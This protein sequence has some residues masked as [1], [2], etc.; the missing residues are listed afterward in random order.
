MT[1]FTSEDDMT[2][3]PFTMGSNNT[4][5]SKP[6]RTINLKPFQISHR[7]IT[8]ADYKYCQ[9]H[10]NNGVVC[11][12]SAPIIIGNTKCNYNQPT[13]QDHP[14]NCIIWDE[15]KKFAEWCSASSNI[16]TNRKSVLPT[17]AQFEY[18]ARD[19]GDPFNYANENKIPVCTDVQFSSTSAGCG[20]GLTV[21]PCSKGIF[22]LNGLF[23]QTN[24]DICDISGNVSEWTMDTYLA[25]YSTSAAFLDGSAYLGT[26]RQNLTKTIRGGSWNSTVASQLLSS[27]ARTFATTITRSAEVGFRL[28]CPIATVSE[29]TSPLNP[30]MINKTYGCYTECGDGIVNG[31]EQCDDGNTN[32]NDGCLDTCVLPPS[33]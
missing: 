14:I 29:A 17:E 8:V 6:L 21:P 13:R 32:N 27:Y 11:S 28:A 33:N 23:Y 7:E 26:A 16:N 2:P 18:V 9:T 3:M 15:A 31:T 4:T 25:P 24:Q 10:P 1:P 5:A 12:A 30:A 19:A 20:T 22:S